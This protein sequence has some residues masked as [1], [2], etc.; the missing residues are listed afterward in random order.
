M[1]ALLVP[2]LIGL[3]L[4]G[5]GG[6]E[7]HGRIDRLTVSGTVSLF[8][9]GDASGTVVTAFPGGH[10]VT[11]DASGA[12]SI[13]VVVGGTV[14]FEHPGFAPVQR[15][16]EADIDLLLGRGEAMDLPGG[17]GTPVVAAHIEGAAA[18]LL[19]DEDEES[20]VVDLVE[21]AP[22]V[23]LPAGWTLVGTVGRWL[24][25]VRGDAAGTLLAVSAATGVRQELRGWSPSTVVGGSGDA[26]LVLERPWPDDPGHRQVALWRPGAEPGLYPTPVLAVGPRLG[27]DVA[28]S[29]EA[30]LVRWGVDGARRLA[31]MSAD[32]AVT[33]TLLDYEE[34]RETLCYVYGE[35]RRVGCNGVDLVEG[36]EQAEA[37]DD[38]LVVWSDGAGC[39]A[40]LAPEGTTSEPFPCEGILARRLNGGP[41]LVVD[42]EDEAHLLGAEGA[43]SLGSA[44]AL[45]VDAHG[46]LAALVLEG[47]L[48][49]VGPDGRVHRAQSL[50]STFRRL[51]AGPTSAFALD[52]RT[53]RWASPGT[54]QQVDVSL[55]PVDADVIAAGAGFHVG[56]GG[57]LFVGQ[58][59]VIRLDEA[60]QVDRVTV[61]P[62]RWVGVTTIGGGL[63]DVGLATLDGGYSAVDLY[64][65]AQD[66]LGPGSV[67]GVVD[68]VAWYAGPDAVYFVDDPAALPVD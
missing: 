32:D 47:R 28:L 25:G 18:L 39:R 27:G 23:Q 40:T 11:T 57:F 54:R 66:P 60:L 43:T 56:A 8:G 1:R 42:G 13:A 46:A 34:P 45:A 53:L 22:R 33:V 38:G 65:G 68:G 15:S 10:S 6:N 37:P 19:W 2:L 58:D 36:V 4:A 31:S 64:T 67:G 50:E 14:R 16:A 52:G 55:D 29:S 26:A 44:A 7:P 20:L 5:C 3:A 41:G 48:A 61:A 59:R 30:G 51:V 9:R 24:V 62:A 21:R 35:P 12:Y 17:F 49:A 63:P